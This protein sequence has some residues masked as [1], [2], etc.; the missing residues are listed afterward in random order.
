MYTRYSGFIRTIHSLGDLALLNLAFLIGNLVHYGNVEHAFSDYNVKQ[1]LYLNLFWIITTSVLKVYKIYRVMRI[2]TIIEILLKAFMVHLLFIF[3]FIVVSKSEL[4]SFELFLLKY[5]IFI[6]L[7]IAWRLSFIYFLKYLR[8]RGLNYRRV[9]IAGA[10]SLGDELLGFFNEHPEYGYRFLGFFDDDS[11][12]ESRAGKLSDIE[13]FTLQKKVDEIYCVLPDVPQ[14]KVQQLIS[15]AD[16]HLIRLKIVPDLRSLYN[17]KV[18]IDFYDN[19]PILNFRREPLDNIFNRAM[20]R[21][22]D[23][24]FSTIVL[25]AVFPWL[26]P[27]IAIA[28]KLSSKGPVLFKQLRSGRGNKPFVCYKFRSM[29]TNSLADERQATKNDPR[30]TKVGHFL[31]KTSLDELPQFLNVLKGEMSVVGPRPHMLLHT[32]K[33]SEEIDSFMVRHFVKAGITGLAQV[34]GLRGETSDPALMDQ[35]VRM[36]LWYIENW[37]FLFD[38]K[39]IILTVLEM[40]RGKIKGA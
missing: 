24:V 26:F 10:G 36:D 25:V 5:C 23:I 3:S 14:E 6:F 20:K 28:V 21:G 17:K 1:F 2:S 9:I 33:Y 4:Y 11:K 13:E 19:L 31:R 30:I 18:K 12:N 22:F 34:K 35:R 32:E 29:A 16:D 37:T 38:I 27:I 39:I 15:F 7:I 8:K 40:M